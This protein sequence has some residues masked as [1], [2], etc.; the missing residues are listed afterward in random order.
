MEMDYD[1]YIEMIREI[2]ADE[3]RLDKEVEVN[4]EL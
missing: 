2:I 3:E 1:A 4:E